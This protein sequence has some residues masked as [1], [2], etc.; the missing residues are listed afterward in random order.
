MIYSCPVSPFWELTFLLFRVIHVSFRHPPWVVQCTTLP[1]NR[2]AVSKRVVLLPILASEIGSLTPPSPQ[3]SWEINEESVGG[4]TGGPL[5][6]NLF[7]CLL[8]LIVL[9]PINTWQL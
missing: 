4:T 6:K 7:Q 8:R 9:S 3:S 1:C 2:C 5:H